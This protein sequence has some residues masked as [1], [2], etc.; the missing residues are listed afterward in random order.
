MSRRVSI[1]PP[2]RKS[3]IEIDQD[4]EDDLKTEVNR[5]DWETVNVLR[6]IDR[7]L[8]ISIDNVNDK[9]IPA[10]ER[11]GAECEEISKFGEMWKLFF[12]RAARV[13]LQAYEEPIHSGSEGMLFDDIEGQPQDESTQYVQQPQPE[14]QEQ[15]EEDQ[16]IEGG[17]NQAFKKPI[18]KGVSLQDDEETPTW[19]TEQASN[20]P[21]VSSTPQK[22][23]KKTITSGEPQALGAT[24]VNLGP[25]KPS[26]DIQ[27]TRTYRRSLDALHRISVSPEKVKEGRGLGT[28][29]RR[30]I[31][32]DILDSSPPFPP[33]PILLSDKYDQNT[34]GSRLTPGEHSSSQPNQNFSSIPRLKQRLSLG[35]GDNGDDM[36]TPLANRSRIMDEELNEVAPVQVSGDIIVQEEEN[37][38]PQLELGTSSAERSSKKRKLNDYNDQDT[39]ENVFI[40]N[41]ANNSTLFFSPNNNKETGGSRDNTSR[42]LTQQF[43]ENLARLSRNSEGLKTPA[44]SVIPSGAVEDVSDIEQLRN[45]MGPLADKYLA[46]RR[47]APTTTKK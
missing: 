40:D 2:K 29:R 14:Q 42:S 8:V 30:T 32:D 23:S 27:I 36:S 33:P 20:K 1:I 10:I 43:E 35:N 15:Q 11:Y 25:P 31:I 44:T 9:L 37:E 7:K 26:T 19:S 39:H 24:K 38:I 46:I 13:E 4:E 28:P 16:G 18:R 21:Y 6:E 12:A 41:S 3:F 47:S 45:E 5:L 34:P 22:G 17:G